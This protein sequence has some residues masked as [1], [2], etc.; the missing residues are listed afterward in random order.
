MQVEPLE[1]TDVKIITPKKFGDHRGFFSETYNRD[2]FEAAGLDLAF[3]QDNHSFSAPKG[4][5]RGLHFQTPPHGQD[6][7][8][9]VIRGAI[10]DVAVDIRKGSPSYGKWVGRV[11]SAEEWNQILVPVGFAHG[12]CTIEENT[13]VLYKVTDIYAP[14]CEGGLTWNDPAIGIDWPLDGDPILSAKDEAYQPF[15]EFDSPFTYEA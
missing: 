2:A 1:I 13:E 11:I 9:R 15:A 3:V 14:D 12:F 6:K 7:L 5:L 8:L 10:F 4:T